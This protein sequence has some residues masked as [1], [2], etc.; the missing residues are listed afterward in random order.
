MQ[1]RERNGV[2]PM[3][4]RRVSVLAAL[5]LAVAGFA[6]APAAAAEGEGDRLVRN[7]VVVEPA[8]VLPRT[9]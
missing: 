7:G 3:K 4:I 1:D 8:L 5:S 9:I 6:A 2:T